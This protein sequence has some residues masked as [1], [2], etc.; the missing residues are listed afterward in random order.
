MANLSSR[1]KALDYLLAH[2]RHGQRTK[3]LFE[4]RAFVDLEIELTEMREKSAD[5]LQFAAVSGRDADP[6]ESGDGGKKRGGSA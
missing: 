6:S 2:C 3:D 5:V 4:K 1:Q